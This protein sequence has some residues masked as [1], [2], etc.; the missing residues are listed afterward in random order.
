MPIY[1]HMDR[2]LEFHMYLNKKSASLLRVFAY[3][4]KFWN[5]FRSLNEILQY[6]HSLQGRTTSF[7]WVQRDWDPWQF[8]YKKASVLGS[9]DR[10]IRGTG[11]MVLGGENRVYRR[12]ICCGA[13]YNIM[14]MNQSLCRKKPMNNSL[15]YKG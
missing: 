10:C 15:N 6:L 7:L 8:P 12:V 9:D 14:N 13:M 1:L 4:H 11:K 3:D 5:Q 2:I